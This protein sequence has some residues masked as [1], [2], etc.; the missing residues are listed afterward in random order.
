MSGL[1]Y[2]PEIEWFVRCGAYAQGERGTSGTMI[3]LLRYGIPSGGGL[4]VDNHTDAQLDGVRR[5]RR[6]GSVYAAISKRARGV[7]AA[8]YG[9]RPW[10]PGILGALGELAGVVAELESER[11]GASRRPLIEDDLSRVCQSL[12]REASVRRAKWLREA[13]QA[14]ASAHGEW[15]DV[16]KLLAAKRA[17]DWVHA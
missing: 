14:S 12:S 10:L 7:L 16:R 5:A 9:S 17:Q 8:R 15:D 3:D 4:P 2:N 1:A 13:E 6:C 11:G